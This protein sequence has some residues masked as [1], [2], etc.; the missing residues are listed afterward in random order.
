MPFTGGPD[1]DTETGRIRSLVV[2]GSAKGCLEPGNLSPRRRRDCGRHRR[3][4]RRGQPRLLQGME[5][6]R[7][8][9]RC[10]QGHGDRGRRPPG[11]RPGHPAPPQAWQPRSSRVAAVPEPVRRE[12]AERAAFRR[13]EGGSVPEHHLR[14]GPAEA[15]SPSG[16]VAGPGRAVLGE[17]GVDPSALRRTPTTSD[18]A[19][20]RPGWPRWCASPSRLG[21]SRPACRLSGVIATAHVDAAPTPLSLMSFPVRSTARRLLHG[22]RRLRHLA[23]LQHRQHHALHGRRRLPRPALHHRSGP[24]G[25]PGLRTDRRGRP[26]RERVIAVWPCGSARRGR[27]SGC[28]RAMR[29]G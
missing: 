20:W 8:E 15:C 19:N 5:D 28:A 1:P 3:S 22:I 9:G 11:H 10:R 25:H 27:A 24:G 26:I 6:V 23:R 12:G 2:T 29:C 13:G 14:S 7:R 17:G 16:G 4:A 21:V 18:S